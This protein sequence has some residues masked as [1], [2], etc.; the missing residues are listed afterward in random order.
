[1]TDHNVNPSGSSPLHVFGG[2]GVRK[3]EEIA[4]SRGADGLLNEPLPEGTNL[5]E[6]CI[7]RQ[8][9]LHSPIELL[10]EDLKHEGGLGGARLKA[11]AEVQSILRSVS[12]GVE[13]SEMV[14]VPAWHLVLIM[15]MAMQRLGE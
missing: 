1:M 7:N 14:Q 15:K 10:L 4:I 12:V 11:L 8:A 5:W 9:Q 3:T 13:P 6:V 2:V